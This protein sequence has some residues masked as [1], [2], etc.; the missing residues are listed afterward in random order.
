MLNIEFGWYLALNNS[1]SISI[2][3][4]EVTVPEHELHEIPLD[5]DGA[6]FDIKIFRWNDKPT[7]EKSYNYL[8]NSTNKIV[9]K[10][11]SRFN[12]KLKFYT[13]A[14]ACSKWADSYSTAND[15]EVFQENPKG[16]KEYRKLSSKLL[17]LQRDIYNEFLRKYVDEEI[18]KY[19]EKGFFPSYLVSP[20]KESK[21]P[22]RF[23]S[24]YK[25]ESR[26][27]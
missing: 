25:D 8:V 26:V 7:S 15:S 14:Y 10:E 20:E 6:T 4:R 13:T 27:F 22:F 12:K 17:D 18:K 9:N 1:Q 21:E 16:T 11:L 24:H 23:Q 5:I 2:N 19:D 3:G